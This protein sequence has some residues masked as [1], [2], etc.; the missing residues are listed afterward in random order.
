[1]ER[2]RKGEG[3]ERIEG[4]EKGDRRVELTYFK[5]SRYRRYLG[6]SRG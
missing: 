5:E 1:M 4:E 3:R 2:E 6:E